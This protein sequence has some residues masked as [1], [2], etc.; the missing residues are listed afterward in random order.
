[1]VCCFGSRAAAERRAKAEEV[2]TELQ[3]EQHELKKEAAEIQRAIKEE[4]TA[5][6]RCDQELR[7]EE[8]HLSQLHSL[9]EAS[10]AEMTEL[11]DTL[12]ARRQVGGGSPGIQRVPQANSSVHDPESGTTAPA[13]AEAWREAERL[14]CE[15]ARMNEEVQTYHSRSKDRD[16]A[17]LEKAEAAAASLRAE[18]AEARQSLTEAEEEGKSLEDEHEKLQ[19]EEEPLQ[20]WVEHVERELR[21]ARTENR[22]LTKAVKAASDERADLQRDEL[23][24][25]PHGST[26]A[27]QSYWLQ[28]Q[29]RE[30][31]ARKAVLLEEIS[32][33]RMRRDHY[34]EQ[35]V[36]CRKLV[37]R[38]FPVQA[39]RQPSK[40]SPLPLAPKHPQKYS[41]AGESAQT[42][43][44]RSDN[45]TLSIGSQHKQ[46]QTEI[47]L[48]PRTLLKADHSV[49]AAESP[50]K[51]TQ[52]EEIKTVKENKPRTI[53]PGHPV[54]RMYVGV[55]P[56]TENVP[57]LPP[58]EE[59]EPPLLSS[60]TPLFNM[61]ASGHG[62][63]AVDLRITQSP[64]YAYDSDDADESSD[65][66]HYWTAVPE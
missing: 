13:L 10:H 17:P 47:Y 43:T 38:E 40:F 52:R 61:L 31:M 7:H 50:H 27:S 58:Y 3:D 8:A 56:I 66:Q 53:S 32:S 2:V 6:A 21:L 18:I 12:N 44:H 41:V 57:L 5:K 19:N 25:F 63:S 65:H 28:E 23:D 26:T 14:M 16:V 4:E 20:E 22:E 11:R 9:S 64:S 55:P 49:L 33:H 36:S 62:D 35:A 39:N 54:P 42:T 51:Q 37:A 15:I 46:K 60:P 34:L 59:S 24:A 30:N 1:M 48:Q 29:E 45:S